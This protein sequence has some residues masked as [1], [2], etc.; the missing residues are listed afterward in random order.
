MSYEEV[1]VF[2][3]S[4]GVIYLMVLFAGVLAYAFWP[5]N[6]ATFDRAAQMPLDEDKN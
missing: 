3:R 5:R 1:S 4:W 2:A 6:K